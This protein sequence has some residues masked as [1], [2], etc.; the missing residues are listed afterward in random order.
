LLLKASNKVFGYNYAKCEEQGHH[1]P[2]FMLYKDRPQI[3]VL[4]FR[5]T[6]LLQKIQLDHLFNRNK[7]TGTPTYRTTSKKKSTTS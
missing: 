4:S 1:G 3:P 7:S 6:L 5:V 2:A